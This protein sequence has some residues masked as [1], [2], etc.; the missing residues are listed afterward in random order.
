MAKSFWGRYDIRGIVGEG[1]SVPEYRNIGRAYAQFIYTRVAQLSQTPAVLTVGVGHDARLHSPELSESLILGLSEM[2]IRVVRLGLKTSPMVYFADFNHELNPAFPQLIGAVSVTASHNPSAYNGAKFTFNQGAT[3]EHDLLE[4]KGY[5][6]AN[7]FTLAET[8][9]EVLDY[10]L[11]P[12]YE[13]WFAKHFGSTVG[14]G[15]KVVVDSS[16]ATAGIVA[17]QIMRALGCEVVELFTEPDGTFPN[18]H[19]DPVIYENLT[20]LIATVKETHADVGICFDGDADRLGI[21]DQHGGIIPGDILTL[22]YAVDYLSRHAGGKA[23]FDIKCTQSLF[24]VVRDL[25][26]TPILTPS[27]HA[28]M[29]SIMK[30]Q[31]IKVGGE[32]S[33]HIFFR[34]RHWGFDDALYAACRLV[35][36]MAEQRSKKPTYQISEFMESLPKTILSEEKRVY[37]DRQDA[38]AL[39]ERITQL[40][41]G[42]ADYFGPNVEEVLTLDGLR[43]N[44]T[45]GFVLIRCSNTEPSITLRYEAGSQAEYD[46]IES[47]LLSLT[48]TLPKPEGSLA[49]TH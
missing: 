30:E 43:V 25:K 45:T 34:D 49:G 10:N 12:D 23:S 17:P 16:N 44:F 42:S 38:D 41:K 19:P 14:N 48:E 13:A 15:L 40:V 7:A 4:I 36:I 8:P 20:T 33:G 24:K 1:F 31:D 11:N 5:Y 35:E 9:A 39:I 22:Y 27:G 3:D 32:L 2:G 37:C 47:R 6:L 28:F 21:V 29:K 26:G 18:H 46:M